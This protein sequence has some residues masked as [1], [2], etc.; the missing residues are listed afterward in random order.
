MNVNPIKYPV[1]VRPSISDISWFDVVG[2]DGDTICECQYEYRAN[3][4]AESLNAVN[5]FPTSGRIMGYYT[6]K[7]TF[8]KDMYM[9]YL[10]FIK[11]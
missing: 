11:R 10:K 2:K 8:G 1:S 9:W 7:S 3:A 4:I 6:A 5:E